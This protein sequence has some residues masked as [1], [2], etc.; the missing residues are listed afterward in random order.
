MTAKPPTWVWMPNQPH[1]T[2]A[3]AKT[4]TLEPFF[5][6]AAR[7]MTGK[8]APYFVPIC[9]EAT[10]GTSTIAFA[11]NTH[12]KA[13]AAVAPS[14]ANEA[15]NRHAGTHT[16]RPIHSPRKSS[17]DHVLSSGR[18]GARSGERPRGA[19]FGKR[20]SIGSFSPR[21]SGKGEED[22]ARIRDRSRGASPLDEKARVTFRRGRTGTPR[23]HLPGACGGFAP[24]TATRP[25]G[26]VASARIATAA[27]HRARSATRTVSFFVNRR[28]LFS[29]AS[30]KRDARDSKRRA[31]RVSARASEGRRR[32]SSREMGTFQLDDDDDAF[33]GDDATFG[34]ARAR[35]YARTLRRCAPPTRGAQIFFASR[36]TTDARRLSLLLVR[37]SPADAPVHPP[38]APA[39]KSTRCVARLRRARLRRSTRAAAAPRLC[40]FADRKREARPPR[41][42][43]CARRCGLSP[44]WVARRRC[45]RTPRTRTRNRASRSISLATTRPAGDPGSRFRATP[46]ATRL[47]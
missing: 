19:V 46:E 37:A 14:A 22:E 44:G 1:P 43:R 11:R 26:P 24:G 40:P 5:P 35:R 34:Y 13:C 21:G 6:N 41:L 23:G 29:R 15:A 3:R 12:E 39:G 25:T 42:R 4:G 47:R 16:T 18:T 45:S 32:P 36:E 7:A 2:S 30:T 9:A 8:G 33:W 38:T 28:R 20:A 31:R 27:R 10:I 17:E